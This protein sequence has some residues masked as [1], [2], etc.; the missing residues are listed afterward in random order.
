M[1]LWFGILVIK[2]RALNNKQNFVMM[3]RER[4]KNMWKNGYVNN[5]CL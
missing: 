2:C 4:K 3:G 5:F 1:N